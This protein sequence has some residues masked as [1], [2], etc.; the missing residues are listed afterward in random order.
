MKK[1]ANLDCWLVRQVLLTPFLATDSGSKA[2]VQYWSTTLG[3]E[4]DG[5]GVP[6][7][8]VVGYLINFTTGEIHKCTRVIPTPRAFVKA[9]IGMIGMEGTASRMHGT[10]TLDWAHDLIHW[11]VHESFLMIT[12]WFRARTWVCMIVL[13]RGC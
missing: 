6:V 9:A 4:H 7:Q 10:I 8:L 1:K 11:G 5:D 13:E 2:F 3:A 12:V